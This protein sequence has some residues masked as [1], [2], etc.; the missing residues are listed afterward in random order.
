MVRVSRDGALDGKHAAFRRSLKFGTQ[1][2]NRAS[3]TVPCVGIVTMEGKKHLGKH[4]A[5]GTYPFRTEAP[6]H[7]RDLFV[8]SSLLAVLKQCLG[9]RQAQLKVSPHR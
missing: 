4:R 7:V 1:T 2:A 3:N 6:Q 9:F 5:G 8:S